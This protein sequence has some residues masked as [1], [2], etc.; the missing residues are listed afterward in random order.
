MAT[1]KIKQV[2]SKIKCPKTQKL[3]LEALGLK[4]VN[5]VVEHED[6]PAIL[7]MVEKV[8]HLVVVEK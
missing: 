3:T 5:A 1:I 2:K 4:K 8:K 6:T 7:G